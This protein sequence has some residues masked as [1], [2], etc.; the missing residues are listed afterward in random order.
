MAHVHPD[1]AAWAVFLSLPQDEPVQMLNLIRLN[2]IAAYPPDHPDHGKGRS[3]AEAYEAYRLATEEVMARLGGR[4]VWS[5]KPQVQITGPVGEA[6]DMAVI[7]E[8]PSAEA[9]IALVRDPV[10]REGVKHRSAAV[11]DARVVRVAPDP[12]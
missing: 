5:G 1:R 12:V 6:W 7:T 2:A 8:Y 11:A 4:R 3:G 10:Y 9:F